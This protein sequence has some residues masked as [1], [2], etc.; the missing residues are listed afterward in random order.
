MHCIWYSSYLD[1]V[2]KVVRDLDGVVVLEAGQALGHHAVRHGPG[3][4]HVSPLGTGDL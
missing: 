3:R 2:L 4:G 1:A